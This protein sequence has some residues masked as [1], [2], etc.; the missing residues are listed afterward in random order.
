MAKVE[1]IQI[2]KPGPPAIVGELHP[3]V[4]QALGF[5]V[6]D[7][8][9]NA[10]ALNIIKRLRAGEQRI[11]DYF[12]PARRA[13]D[14]AK[15]EILAARDGLIVPIAAARGIYDRR[16]DE[17]EQVERRKAAEEER[18]LQEMARKQEEDRVLDEAI[19]AERQGDTEAASQILGEELDVPIVTVAP[20]VAKVSGMSKRE[21]WSA[22][23]ENL[24]ELVAYVHN[25]PEWISLLDANMPN[26][27]RLAVSQHKA[28]NIPGVRA[29]SKS[30]RSTRI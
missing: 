4:E 26:L 2:E 15:K 16:A 29:V 21:T 27:N 6:V 13:A 20:A 22:E 17:Y 19:E 18:R 9:S 5:R 23:I 7:V 24:H 1:T 10:E 25:H 12:E 11:K 14:K 3:Y 28:L 30:S 8:D